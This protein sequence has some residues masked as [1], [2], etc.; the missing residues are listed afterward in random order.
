[1]RV[2]VTGA[3]GKTGRLVVRRL[4]QL[5]IE[6]FVT[7]ALVRSAESE[8]ELRR[9]LGR[10]AQGL[11]VVHGDIKKID[12]LEYAFRGIDAVIVLTSSKPQVNRLSQ[13][14]AMALKFASLGFSASQPSYDFPY[15]ESPQEIDWVGQKNQVDVAK[16]SGASHIVLV[17]SM[18]GAKPD[19][20][21]NTQ[22]GD[23]ALFKRKAEHYLLES[24][25]PYT[26]IHAGT[27]L[28]QLDSNLPALGGR[29]QLFI[30]VDDTLLDERWDHFTL[31]REDLARV[32]VDCLREPLAVGRSFDLGSGQEGSN[33]IYDGDLAKLLANLRGLN[34]SYED[35]PWS[36]RGVRQPG[37]AQ[38]LANLSVDRL[39][40]RLSPTPT[41]T[42]MATKCEAKCSGDQSLKSARMREAMDSEAPGMTMVYDDRA[43]AKG[44]K[45]LEQ[46]T[47][48]P[49]H[50]HDYLDDGI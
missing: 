38:M 7:R 41:C 13:A 14:G 32:C 49:Y 36:P 15:G 6:S 48:S 12:T 28:P 33:E 34:C 39:L 50:Y 19:H 3:A 30:G 4:L 45:P 42:S 20:H 5:G 24:G 9:F 37:M 47:R 44:R 8:A 11:E 18:A 40:Q 31:T 1:M 26:I 16:A 29:R 35:R 21:V 10:L 25:L 22:M 27:L 17:S 46:K 23:M 2:L 43:L